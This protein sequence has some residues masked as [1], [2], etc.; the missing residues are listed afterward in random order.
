MSKN[1]VNLQ[2]SKKLESMEQCV[3]ALESAGGNLRTFLDSHGGSEDALLFHIEQELA[4]T[5]NKELKR[6]WETALQIS[7]KT[8][9]DRLRCK[10]FEILETY[11]NESTSKA[12]DIAFSRAMLVGILTEDSESVKYKYRPATT[13]GENPKTQAE[14]DADDL[15]NEFDQAEAG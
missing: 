2:A 1:I 12:S 7:A 15:L 9:M 13:S 10:A 11:K 5:E 6:R 14:Q 8:R 4:K 3:T